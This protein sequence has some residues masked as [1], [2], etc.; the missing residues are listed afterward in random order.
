MGERKVLNKYFPPDFDPAKLPK[1][2]RAQN[3]EMKVR[4]MLPFSLRCQ[5]CGVFMYKGTK[6]NTR[7][8][9]VIGENYLGIQVFRFYFRCS[10][11]SAE[12]TFKTD[13]KNSD[14]VA[15]FG[16]TRNYEPWRESDVVA[17]ETRAAREEE[18]KGNAMK[19]LENRTLDSKREMDILA[20]LDEMRSLKAR[21]ERIGVDAA[22]E[23]LRGS[24]AEEQGRKEGGVELDPEDEAALRRVFGGKGGEVVRRIQEDG[25]RIHEDGGRP[26]RAPAP[27]GGEQQ[28]AKKKAAVTIKAVVKPKV[29]KPQVAPPAGGGPVEDG[30]AALGA[31][32]SSEDTD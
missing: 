30:L 24:V 17:E 5:T 19:A 9:D 27:G 25:G 12:I 32:G 3:N 22:L 23:A 18:E 29:V 2:K 31:Y 28:P 16:A 11:C 13:P 4:M 6:F 10:K 15:E 20:A 14:Y 8:E 26:K 21:Q 7:K 1:G